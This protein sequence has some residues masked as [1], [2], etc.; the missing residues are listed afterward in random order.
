MVVLWTAGPL[1]KG[2][3]CSSSWSRVTAFQNISV[4]IISLCFLRELGFLTD[5]FLLLLADSSRACVRTISCQIP[6]HSKWKKEPDAA[7]SC[8]LEDSQS[9]AYS[10]A[11]WRT[12]WHLGRGD[13]GER[14]TIA[15]WIKKSI[16]YRKMCFFFCH[17]FEHHS[18][19]SLPCI[20]LLF[21]N[22]RVALEKMMCS[23]PLGGVWYKLKKIKLPWQYNSMSCHCTALWM[24][25]RLQPFLSVW[26]L[27]HSCHFLL[28]WPK[29]W[30]LLVNKQVI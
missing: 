7:S 9:C 27:C 8:P 29:A 22:I 19:H 26:P 18:Q 30:V 15:F 28:Q 10:M 16:A 11:G 24:D 12:P 14:Q 21:L 23:V 25:T 1:F 13:A 3:F 17:L 20:P 2:F 4:E 5:F 6:G